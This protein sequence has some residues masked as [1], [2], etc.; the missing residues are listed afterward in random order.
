MYVNT[1]VN[2]IFLAVDILTIPLSGLILIR[3]RASVLK[4]DASGTRRISA[5]RRMSV[6]AKES[7]SEAA[8]TAGDLLKSEYH[9]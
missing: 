3:Y 9:Y 4:P 1:P 5:F 7:V 8:L 2:C 6:I